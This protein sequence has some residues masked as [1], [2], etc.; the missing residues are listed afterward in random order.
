MDILF[1]DFNKEKVGLH[2]VQINIPLSIFN[3]KQELNS[4]NW[5]LFSL[6]K[7]VLLLINKI[8]S[9]LHSL[10]KIPF[11]FSFFSQNEQFAIPPRVISSQYIHLL[12]I[13]ILL[14]LYVQLIQFPSLSKLY[15]SLHLSHLNLLALFIPT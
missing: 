5:T 15:P 10:H 14:D 13:R 2:L 3:S 9:S 7:Q 6:F 11:S 4:S 1:S 12:P 8:Y